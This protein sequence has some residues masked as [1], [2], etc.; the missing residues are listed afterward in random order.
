MCIIS[1]ISHIFFKYLIFSMFRGFTAAPFISSAQLSVP[2]SLS[3]HDCDICC[4]VTSCELDL[5]SYIADELIHI[6]LEF[7]FSNCLCVF[8]WFIVWE[9]VNTRHCVVL[10]QPTFVPSRIWV[11]HT[12]YCTIFPRSHVM[13]FVPYRSSQ[14]STLWIVIPIFLCVTC[15]RQVQHSH[16]FLSFTR[17]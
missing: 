9:W 11:N 16:T 7:I 3:R 17:V 4:P 15:L 14:F 13:S 1:W 10:Y 12:S 8:D 6:M 5:T 2:F